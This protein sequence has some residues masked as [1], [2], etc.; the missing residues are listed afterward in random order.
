VLVVIFRSD[1]VAGGSCIACELDIFLGDV[2]CSSSDFDIRS[3]GFEHPCHRVLTTP[4]I[5]IIVII[6]VPVTHP[7]VVL[8]VSH[9]VPL[10]PA[11]KLPCLELLRPVPSTGPGAPFRFVQC[12]APFGPGHA[13]AS[14]A[15]LKPRLISTQIYRT[16]QS[17]KTRSPPARRASPAASQ[18]IPPAKTATDFERDFSSAIS[19]FR[20]LC[21]R[22]Q[23]SLPKPSRSKGP[24]FWNLSPG[25]SRCENSGL[26]PYLPTGPV[27]L[28]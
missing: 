6:V 7:L 2:R 13:I 5:V 11:L 16:S 17:T 23:R 9:I 12:R 3:V 10:I 15:G 21:G 26:D 28:D 8:T 25:G 19:G 4:V 14:R 18:V 24:A 27:T 1:R 20:S 22:K